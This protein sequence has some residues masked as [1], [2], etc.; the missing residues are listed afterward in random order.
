[1]VDIIRNKAEEKLL[2]A[3]QD[4]IYGNPGGRCLLLR[5]SQIE[6]DHE[7]MLPDILSAMENAM[8]EGHGQIFIC[9]DF[10]VLII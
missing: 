9:H 8:T 2:L 5:F 10:D 1:M 4:Q 6:C 3:L 7:S